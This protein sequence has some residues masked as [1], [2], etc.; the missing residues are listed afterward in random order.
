MKNKIFLRIFLGIIIVLGCV[1]CVYVFNWVIIT[2]KSPDAIQ[3]DPFDLEGMEIT[4]D[5]VTLSIS[6]GGGCEE[7]CFSLHMSPATFFESYPAQ[8][9][10][11]LRHDS[12]GD[13]CEALISEEISFNLRP[14][15]LL[16]KKI[17]GQFDVIVINVFEYK[18]NDKLSERYSPE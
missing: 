2:D 13:A 10:L 4:G 18:S 8:A 6:Y 14:V 9:N 15:A 16:Y 1:S 12:N 7:H 3:L 17:Y 11:Y 5:T